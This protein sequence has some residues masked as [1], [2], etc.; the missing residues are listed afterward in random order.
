MNLQYGLD[1]EVEGSIALNLLPLLVQSRRRET[2]QELKQYVR[3]LQYTCS[4]CIIAC[5]ALSIFH[6]V[7]V[8][9]L[10]LV[11]SA[12]SGI[13]LSSAAAV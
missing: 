4:R 7:T 9:V 8:F 12:V 3:H 6:G 11:I 1:D 2:K 13:I 10:Q 5:E